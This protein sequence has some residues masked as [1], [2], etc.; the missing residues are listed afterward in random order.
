MISAT[1]R[2][3]KQLA[4]SAPLRPG[5]LMMVGSEYLRLQRIVV[6]GLFRIYDHDITLNLD[7][8]VT[9]LH[10]PNGVGKTV[11][12]GMI[13][14]LLKKNFGYFRN[15][16]FSRLR[17]EFHDGSVLQLESENATA[18]DESVYALRLTRDR[19]E[20]S[21]KV[22]GTSKADV[23]AARIGFLRPNGL[24][25]QTWVDVR[26]GEVLTAQEVL[27][28]FSESAP[29][30]SGGMDEDTS[31]LGAFLERANA[32]LIEAQRLVRM[33]RE[34]RTQHKLWVGPW[35]PSM[36]STVVECSQDFRTRLD[37]TMVQYGRQ[38]QTLDQSFPQRLLSAGENLT[39]PELQERMSILDRKTAELK[40]IGTLDETPGHPFPVTNL[41]KDDLT[42]ASVMTLYVRDTAKKLSAL[43][44]LA[45]RT[46]LLLD[47]VNQK[48]RHKRIQLDRE[49]G[50]VAESEDGKR[51]PLNSLSSG[52][53]HE[54][55][56]HYDLLFRVR[57]NT[58]V[59]IDEPEL[60]LHVLWQKRFLP[61]LLEIV[62]VSEFDALVATHSPY[63]V[64]E[65]NDLMVGL[66]DAE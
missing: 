9:L 8:R 19:E 15:V 39:V 3:R 17:L 27:S 20:R 65:R 43:E 45:S 24:F 5:D 34:P 11:V 31:W 59:L 32:H 63:V 36:V 33:D 58:I 60:S 44:D 61:D 14:A 28:R 55:V 10:G 62:K 2:L 38:S 47:N 64:G 23:V 50:L 18:V 54:L 42:Q 22:T 37:D 25:P 35:T 51:L 40:E 53:Q 6:D 13:N 4:E 26:D 48:Y 56:L 21:A 52:E 57:S 12:L 41:V 7:S 46:R 16:P 49:E 29:A 66:G 1:I 30:G